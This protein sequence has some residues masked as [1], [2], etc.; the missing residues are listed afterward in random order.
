LE[1]ILIV[2]S[3]LFGLII[4]S[5][6]NALIYRLPREINIAVPRSSCPSCN[7]VISWYENIPVF[8]YIFLKGRCSNCKTQISWQY[9]LVELTTGLF[10]LAIA[11]RTIAPSE[12]FSFFFFLGIFSAFLVHFIVDLKHQIL[13]DSVNIYPVSYTHLTLPTTPYV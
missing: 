3:A 10:A 1:N 8:S 13:P 7:H 2:F 6:L 11:P 12:L 5:F 9:P 4:G